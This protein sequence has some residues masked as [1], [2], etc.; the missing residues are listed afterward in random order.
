MEELDSPPTRLISQ[1]NIPTNTL[2]SQLLYST[3]EFSLTVRTKNSSTRTGHTPA[4]HI[5]SATY[6]P[7]KSQRKVAKSIAN[8]TT[9]KGYRADLSTMALARASAILRSQRP[10]V[11][12]KVK[13]RKPRG[14][15]A[16]KVAG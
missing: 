2:A 15:K 8:T 16:L 10:K 1:T 9:R 14:K 11:G 12:Q 6:S 13:E 3:S 7:Y 4:K 5:S